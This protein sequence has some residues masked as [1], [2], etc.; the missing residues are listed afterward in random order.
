MSGRSIHALELNP[1]Y[2]DVAIKRW[3][4]FTGQP[5]ILESTG[6]TFEDVN[7]ARYAG[8]EWA[9]NTAGSY[10]VGIKE[11]REKLVASKTQE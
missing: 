4:D 7:E 11:L 8:G 2:V 1:A 6:Q 10:D 9:K 3:Q 5:A